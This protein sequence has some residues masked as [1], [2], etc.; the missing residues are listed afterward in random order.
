[1]A[2]R[3]SEIENLAPA[4]LEEL[5]L[6]G[7]PVA[8]DEISGHLWHGWSLAMPAPLFKL[9]GRFGK[10]FVH[11]E[12]RG[13]VRGWNVRMRQGGDGWEPALFRGRPIT[14]GHYVAVAEPPGA[15]AARYPNAFLIDY[16]IGGNRSWDPL[17]RV[18]DWVV[19]LDDDLLLGRMYLWLGGRN[20]QT[21]SWFGLAR[22]EL[23]DDLVDPPVRV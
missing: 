15:L 4:E 23:V 10:T 17:A 12:A 13:V 6:A 5:M 14:Y 8:L 21:P 20:V 3:F 16:G 19:A 11:D 22:G 2:E 18:R 1:V 7:Q 9:F